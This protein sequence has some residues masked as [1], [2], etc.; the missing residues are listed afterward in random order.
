M[1]SLSG[2]TGDTT[3][4]TAVRNSECPPIGDPRMSLLFT[5]TRLGALAL[6]HR[7][8]HAPTTRLRA[9]ADEAPSP[10]MVEYYR[11]RA[12]AGGLFVTESSHP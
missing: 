10:M 4:S 11:Q 12:S 9:L 6:D 5:P 8:V 3:L 7:V 2:K 1:T